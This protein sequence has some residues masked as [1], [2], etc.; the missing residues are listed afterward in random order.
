[1]GWRFQWVS[2][3]ANDFNR[4]YRVSFKKD[5]VAKG[6]IYNF[7]TT[8]FPSDEAP[9]LSVFHKDAA[10]NIFHTYSTYG[11]GLEE[12]L[13]PYTFLDRVPKGR[14]ES[15]MSPHP[16]AWVRHHD[17]YSPNYFAEPAESAARANSSAAGCCAEHS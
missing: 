16:M 8:G 10:S 5:E 14:D 15:A 3:Y 13:G 4:D 6:N 12:L 17:R 1:M 2:S 11:R 7:D 9:G